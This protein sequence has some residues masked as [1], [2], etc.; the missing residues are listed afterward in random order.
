MLKDMVIQEAMEH[1]EEMA[2]KEDM[3]ANLAKEAEEMVLTIKAKMV[4]NKTQKVATIMNKEDKE[5]V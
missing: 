3:V 5:E 4:D 1:E 2:T